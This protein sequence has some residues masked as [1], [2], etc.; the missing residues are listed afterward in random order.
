MKHISILTAM[1]LLSAPAHAQVTGPEGLL[2]RLE[3]LTK[4]LLPMLRELEDTIRNAPG[5]YPPEVLPN[6]D[7]IIRR[8]PES[9]P[10]P[11]P[12][13]DAPILEPLEL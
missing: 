6:G 12:S 2:D 5:Y 10:L 7:I 9:D 11:E 4:P 13:E 3:E 8:I 1:L